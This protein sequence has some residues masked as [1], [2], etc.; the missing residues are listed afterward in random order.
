MKKLICHES[1]M[2]F[3]V[4]K[5]RI[6]E[7]DDFSKLPISP[8]HQYNIYL[9]WPCRNYT[10]PSNCWNVLFSSFLH[11][12]IFINF[13]MGFVK[14]RYSI[15]DV[16][17]KPEFSPKIMFFSLFVVSWY[18]KIVVEIR[19]SWFFTLVLRKQIIWFSL[20]TCHFGLI[21]YSPVFT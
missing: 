3:T 17:K 19:L 6:D 13:L 14:L 1:V 20:K 16:I 4:L 8:C 18:R 7:S 5:R 10:K 15:I 9:H 2:F 12:Q 11:L 21:S